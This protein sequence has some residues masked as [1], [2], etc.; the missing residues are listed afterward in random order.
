MIT[1]YQ[2]I[3]ALKDIT[4][5]SLFDVCR[6]FDVQLMTKDGSA[7]VCNM[8]QADEMNHDG[9][10]RSE[11]IQQL[12]NDP[13][14]RWSRIA[15]YLDLEQTYQDKSQQLAIIATGNREQVIDWLAW[16]DSNGIYTDGDCMAEGLPVFNLVTAVGAMVDVLTAHDPCLDY[17][18][19][20]Y[21]RFMAGHGCA[22]ETLSGGAKF[23]RAKINYL[24]TFI[25]RWETVEGEMK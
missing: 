9:V 5:A 10:N 18:T 21:A 15:D 2:L 13:D 19:T 4:P 20:E 14:F 12:L 25:E 8:E 3:Q 17:L 16:N 6:A 23:T 22:Y 1:R 11:V 7:P 24:K